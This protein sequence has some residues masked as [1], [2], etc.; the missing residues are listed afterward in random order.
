MKSFTYTVK[1]ELGIHAR[2]AGL[3]AKAAGAYK[4][5]VMI[6]NGTKKADAKRLMAI[7]SMGVK[8]GVT[9]TVTVE[10][11]DEDIAAAAI[12]EFFKTNL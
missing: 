6:D 5:V 8:K 12:E 11:E 10:G 4:S 2:P 9:V 1:D 7:M 3:L